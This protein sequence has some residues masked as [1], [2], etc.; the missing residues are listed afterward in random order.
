MMNEKK[1]FN[2]TL[3]QCGVLMSLCLSLLSGCSERVLPH[4][5]QCPLVPA[6]LLIPNAPPPFTI[7]IWGDYPGYVEQLHKELQKC[8]TDKV[9]VATLLKANTKEESKQ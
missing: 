1:N 5:V 4:N 6:L 2:A 8:N 9:A 3:R 7:K